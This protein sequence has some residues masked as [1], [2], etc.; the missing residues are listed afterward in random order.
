MQSFIT[1]R[2]Q[3]KHVSLRMT[4]NPRRMIY[5]SIS[6]SKYAN[7]GKL[8]LLLQNWTLNSHPHGKRD[9][10]WRQRTVQTLVRILLFFRL[11]RCLWPGM[12]ILLSSSITIL[13]LYSLTSGRHLLH[14]QA[15]RT[16][17]FEGDNTSACKLPILD[18]WHATV[19]SS[20]RNPAP[21]FCNDE[22]S[23]TKLIDGVLYVSE[24]V[25]TFVIKEIV[26]VEKND[27][28]VKYKPLNVLEKYEENREREFLHKGKKLKKYINYIYIYLFINLLNRYLLALEKHNIK[29]ENDIK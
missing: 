2:T 22:K 24:K 5:T 11:R 25:E 3:L 7:M 29:K 12:C 13:F 15:K 23:Y 4:K 9:V 26:R 16:V 28:K 21:L 27:F 19:V 20:I 18:P 1:L 6:S 14:F 17:N 10:T 8:K